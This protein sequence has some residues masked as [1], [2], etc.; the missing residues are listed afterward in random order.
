MTRLRIISLAIS[1]LAAIVN[2]LAVFM[3][4]ERL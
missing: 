2:V 4:I 1:L 3:L